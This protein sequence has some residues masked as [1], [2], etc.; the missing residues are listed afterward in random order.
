VVAS[1]EEGVVEHLLGGGEP[2][3]RQ[4][5]QFERLQTELFSRQFFELL[6]K[7]VGLA[8]ATKK[9]FFLRRK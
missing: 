8:S 6:A 5:R 3:D 4:R 7:C 9:L 1:P 2:V